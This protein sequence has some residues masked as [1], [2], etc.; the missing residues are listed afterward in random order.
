MPHMKM[1]ESKKK[2]YCMGRP[3]L[4]YEVRNKKKYFVY[5]LDVRWI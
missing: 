1:K 3:F 4:C 2:G 5:D